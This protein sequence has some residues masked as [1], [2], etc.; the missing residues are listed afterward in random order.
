[1]VVQHRRFPRAML[2]RVKQAVMHA[3]GTLI[4]VVLNNVDSRHDEGYSYYNSY[5]EYYAP[6][7]K[8]APRLEPI[9]AAA[10]ARPRMDHGDY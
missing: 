6:K 7:P 10:P 4:G 8:P 2:Q 1:M 5:N 3:G 9:A